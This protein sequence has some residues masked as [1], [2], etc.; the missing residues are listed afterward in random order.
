MT[1][2]L[3]PAAIAEEAFS[4][5]GAWGY[6]RDAGLAPPEIRG[7]YAR[8]DVD[9]AVAE[10]LLDRVR[11]IGESRRF[12]DDR[13]SRRLGRRMVAWAER[14]APTWWAVFPTAHVERELA[15]PTVTFR[16]GLRALVRGSGRG[17]ADRLGPTTMFYAPCQRCVR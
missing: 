1:E 9:P 10:L 4:P 15:Y 11:R 7:R 13:D 8:L 17:Q 6:L 16:C 2:L 5:D 12:D 14:G 3:V